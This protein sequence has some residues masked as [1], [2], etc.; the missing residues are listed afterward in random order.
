LLPHE[1]AHAA[2]HMTAVMVNI[3]FIVLSVYKVNYTE[4]NNSFDDL[5]P[6]VCFYSLAFVYLYP[7]K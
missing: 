1:M 3:F 5:F 7:V 4:N 2:K 6:N